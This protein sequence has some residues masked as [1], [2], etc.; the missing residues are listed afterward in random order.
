[1][2]VLPPYLENTTINVNSNLT[3]VI[4]SN[5][6]LYNINLLFDHFNRK[7]IDNIL[8]KNSILS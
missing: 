7:R 2:I 3:T 6:I 4:I 5:S 1:M 8:I